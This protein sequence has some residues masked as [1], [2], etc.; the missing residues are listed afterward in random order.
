MFD[1]DLTLRFWRSAT[2]AFFESG[3]ATLAAASTL[4]E[5]FVP[6]PAKPE[7]PP[8]DALNP[9]SWATTWC[10]VAFPATAPA[11]RASETRPQ[12]IFD[13]NVWLSAWMPGIRP[14]VPCTP[15]QWMKLYTDFWFAN[16][17]KW[18]PASPWTMWQ[19]PL[20]MMMM[21]AGMPYAVA[22]PAARAS[23][24]TMDAADA[25]REQF[26]RVFS[27]YRSDGGHAA[28]AVAQWPA[29]AAPANLRPW[30][31]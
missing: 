24:A 2:E 12:N 15:D 25:A 31:H 30:L 16:S 9:M 26:A 6:P 21:S 19:T 14:A 3:S 17:L 18:P 4:H 22:S 28:A 13:P 10:Q 1:F 11:K 5:R 7:P 27:A 8:F 29:L 20:T 23:T